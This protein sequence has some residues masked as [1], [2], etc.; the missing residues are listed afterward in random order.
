MFR[1]VG[2]IISLLFA[3]ILILVVSLIAALLLRF[4]FNVAPEFWIR[5]RST[6]F[7][8]LPLKLVSLLLFGQFRTLLTYFSL[9]DAKRIAAAMGLSGLCAL[10]V[11]FATGG[12]NVVPRGVIVSDIIISFLAL[13]GFRTAL[14]IYRE[15]TTGGEI[16]GQG[17]SRKRRA[18]IIGAGSA[19]SALLRDI[20]GRLGLGLEVV[21]FID[22]DRTKIG[23]L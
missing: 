23:I 14:R 12:G 10:A 9:P 18:A 4:D 1:F 2:R 13:T 19:G 8:L 15:N 6:I 21:C 20:Q 11:W 17:G 22:D 5:L 7:W 16:F 3:Y